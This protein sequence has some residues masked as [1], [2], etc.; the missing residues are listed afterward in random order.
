MQTMRWCFLLLVLTCG[1]ETLTPQGARVS[2]YRASLDGLP[3]QR[4]MPAGCRLLSKQPPVTMTEL[5]IE[6][7]AAEERS[8]N[9]KRKR[10]CSAAPC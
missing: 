4:A 8:L 2:V 3:A 9:V 6:G 7:Q 10:Q 1:C 5:D